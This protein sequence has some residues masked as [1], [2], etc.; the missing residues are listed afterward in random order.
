MVLMG[1]AV[2]GA[3]PTN[4]LFARDLESRSA[5]AVGRYHTHHAAKSR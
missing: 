4:M 3:E 1:E 2:L 5:A